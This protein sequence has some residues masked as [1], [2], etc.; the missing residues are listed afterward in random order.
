MPDYSEYIVFASE[1]YTVLLSIFDLKKPLLLLCCR[2]VHHLE[3]V[4]SKVPFD[5]RT[6]EWVW[7]KF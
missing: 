1:I 6:C 5:Q 3:D 7:S 2:L 4:L